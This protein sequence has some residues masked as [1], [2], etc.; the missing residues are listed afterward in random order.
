MS[1]YRCLA[2]HV[3]DHRFYTGDSEVHSHFNLSK[4][5]KMT[6]ASVYTHVAQTFYYFAFLG[7]FRCVFAARFLIIVADFGRTCVFDLDFCF[8]RRDPFHFDQN[9]F[10]QMNAR[11]SVSRSVAGSHACTSL[12]LRVHRGGS[13]VVSEKSTGS[14]IK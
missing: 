9:L 1:W 14:R 11:M 12:T 10:L 4:I 8:L 13:G 6:G 7:G 3:S 5:V 2:M